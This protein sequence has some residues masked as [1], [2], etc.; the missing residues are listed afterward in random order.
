MNSY[1]VHISLFIYRKIC[2]EL[3]KLFNDCWEII[4]KFMLVDS[5]KAQLYFDYKESTRQLVKICDLLDLFGGVNA[6][7][8]KSED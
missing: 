4:N 2:H 7:L 6:Q 8:V 5:H 3:T 1:F